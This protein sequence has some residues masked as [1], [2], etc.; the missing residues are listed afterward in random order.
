DPGPQPTRRITIVQRLEV[1]PRQ[2]GGR[3]PTRMSQLN[4]RNCAQ[5]T[6]EIGNPAI[7]RNVTVRIYARALLCL[8]PALFP[9][10]FFHAY[11]AGSDY[12]V[13]SQADKMPVGGTTALR[14]IL[15]H[16]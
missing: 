3:L 4:C 1:S 2:V 5:P 8:A 15:A 6:D 7:S 13:F 9:C 11:H 14:A 12:C 16:W 10:S